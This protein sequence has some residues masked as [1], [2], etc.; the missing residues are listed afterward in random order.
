VRVTRGGLAALTAV[1]TLGPVAALVPSAASQDPVAVLPDLIQDVPKNVQASRAHAPDGS[2]TDGFAI[3]F[4]SALRNVGPGPLH[5]L[6]TREADGEM[7]A[8]QFLHAGAADASPVAG[9][10]SRIG[11]MRYITTYGHRHWHLLRMERYALRN[12]TRPDIVVRDRKQGFCFSN[13]YAIGWC[14]ENRRRASAVPMG[15]RAD[16]SYADV[17]KA[18]V[19]GQEI[20]VTRETAPSGRYDLIHT[21]NPAGRV[22]EANTA[23]NSSSVEIALTWRENRRRA[24]RV[25]VLKR[26]PG[27]ATCG[28]IEP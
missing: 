3:S 4:D 1:V 13:G 15:L 7:I 27:S 24:P 14:S 21:A 25:Q 16:P 9:S 2:L 10:V 19:E 8:A 6:G 20:E 17:Y 11:R 26:C 23:N 18:R 12:L 22:R 28:V 5:I